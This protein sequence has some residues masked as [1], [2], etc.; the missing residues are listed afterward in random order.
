MSELEKKFMEYLEK[1]YKL[2]GHKYSKL[3]KKQIKD[4][5]EIA[6]KY[7]VNCDKCLELCKEN[8][9]LRKQ[10]ELM[11]CTI[12]EMGYEIECHKKQIEDNK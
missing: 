9:E 12:N 11:N 2:G 3:L 6:A 1:K 8:A 5:A 7:Y 10:N 4:F